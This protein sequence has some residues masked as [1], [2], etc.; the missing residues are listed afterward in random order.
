LGGTRIRQCFG[1][2]I[3][4]GTLGRA[5]GKVKVP[6]AVL[7]VLISDYLNHILKEKLN[8]QKN[9]LCLIVSSS[10]SKWQD[11]IVNIVSYINE[12]HNTNIIN[13]QK[14]KKTKT[15][16]IWFF[17]TLSSWNINGNSIIQ[18]YDIFIS[19]INYFLF[20]S[21]LL[22]CYI[23]YSKLDKFISIWF[24]NCSDDSP[25]RVPP[26]GSG[27]TGV[28]MHT[29]PRSLASGGERR[30]SK[31]Y[32]VN[33]LKLLI[34]V[35]AIILILLFWPGNYQVLENWFFIN[36]DTIF[37][38]TIKFI[39]AIIV[40]FIALYINYKTVGLYNWKTLLSIGSIFYIIFFIFITYNES[41]SIYIHN[42]VEIY[43][44]ANV[45]I[46]INAF[47]SHF[48][49]YFENN[50]YISNI[51]EI[52]PDK[53]SNIKLAK[54]PN[55]LFNKLETAEEI[56]LRDIATPQSRLTF[57]DPSRADEIRREINL[58]Q[59]NA[60]QGSSIYGKLLSSNVY[61][62]MIKGKNLEKASKVLKINPYDADY[63]GYYYHNTMGYSA[64]IIF[65]DT[66]QRIRLRSCLRSANVETYSSD[67]QMKKLV[68]RPDF[69]AH[70][71]LTYW[72]HTPDTEYRE[73]KIL[74]FQ[75]MRLANDTQLERD[76]MLYNQLMTQL[77]PASPTITLD[78]LETKALAWFKILREGNPDKIR[79]V[80]ESL[81]NFLYFSNEDPNTDNIKRLIGFVRECELKTYLEDLM[82]NWDHMIKTEL[83]EYDSMPPIR[84]RYWKTKRESIEDSLDTW[85]NM[86]N[87]G[88]PILREIERR[89][90]RWEAEDMG[91]IQ[92]NNNNN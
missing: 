77:N 75:K 62:D 22:S 26:F 41:F 28:N 43:V 70:R 92:N 11:H 44:I 19:N 31:T 30:D 59:E 84:N 24:D 68:R 13:N 40:N 7:V 27:P 21:I 57:M 45:I 72:L 56:A 80:S 50:M 79:A 51:K 63:E 20:F 14:D 39:L 15:S 74:H 52:L 29:F 6:K 3:L 78:E 2:V 54:E 32:L 34:I 9:S 61:S 67:L 10:L 60:K 83:I 37:Y 64:Q 58:S 36:N 73:M 5:G 4:Y 18:I 87:G 16:S 47:C 91:G 1:F 35:F 66:Y 17:A 88:S 89:K 55:I 23:I 53:T 33:K 42:K 76:L 49:M 46:F 8:K 69:W 38:R 71:Q 48:F 85:R 65:H 90:I 86:Y 82:S 12:Y 81:E 25:Q